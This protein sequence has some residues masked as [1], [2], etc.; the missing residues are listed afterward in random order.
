MRAEKDSLL[1][2]VKRKLRPRVRKLN[3]IDPLYGPDNYSV[4]AEFEWSYYELE[5]GDIRLSIGRRGRR[6]S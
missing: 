1:K 4:I 2:L 6:T 5:I 3:F